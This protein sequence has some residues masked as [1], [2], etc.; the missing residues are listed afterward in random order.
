MQME[1]LLD[2]LPPLG[3]G[4]SVPVTEYFLPII[5][6]INQL[7][8]GSDLK[9]KV[10]QK[11]TDV[12]QEGHP[13]IRKLLSKIISNKV[14][15]P[16]SSLRNIDSFKE[17]QRR[18]ARG[19]SCLIMMEH[20][21]NMDFPGLF[22]LCENHPE[23]GPEFTER[24]LPLKTYKLS[25]ENET[26]H[27]WT[28]AFASITIFP[29]QHIDQ[30]TDPEELRRVREI[31]TPM[32]LAAIREMTKQKYQ[33]KILLVFPTGTR[34]RK[35]QPVETQKAVREA[36]NYLR[37]FQNILFLGINGVCI[38]ANPD[39]DMGKD[40]IQQDIMVICASEICRG[41]EFR[42]QV[43]AGS[44]VDPADKAAVKEAVCDAIMQKLFALHKEGERVYQKLS[45][46]LAEKWD[47]PGRYRK[48]LLDP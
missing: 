15:L 41:R 45:S 13:Q 39:G 10:F 12:Y 34:L 28:S 40:L 17:L 35:G 29:S 18:S 32:N 19:E 26:V 33:G 25:V 4:K 23:L 30:I 43:I 44:G 42:E 47:L 36:E 37:V 6:K 5:D 46:E 1:S 8:F 11:P 7:F 24:L 38:P 2:L 9:L 14:L 48:N 31:S 20:Y 22:A 27:L 21:G 3:P 16:G